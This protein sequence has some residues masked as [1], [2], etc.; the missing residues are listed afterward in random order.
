MEFII[1][2]ISGCGLYFLLAPPKIESLESS[3]E[4]P[5]KEKIALI[6]VMAAEKSDV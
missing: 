2:L 5:M 1:I 3:S 6:S 4:E